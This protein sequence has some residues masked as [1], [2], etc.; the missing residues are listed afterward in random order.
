[1]NNEDISQIDNTDKYSEYSEEINENSKDN[2]KVN[3]F[4]DNDSE[5]NS[6]EDNDDFDK[7]SSGSFSDDSRSDDSRSEDSRSEDS[8]S[9]DSRSDD[10]RSEDSRSEDSRSDDSRSDKDLENDK[11]N[12]NPPIDLSNIVDITEDLKDQYVDESDLLIYQNTNKLDITDITNNYDEMSV[13][14][15]KEKCKEKNLPVSGNKTKLIERLK[16]N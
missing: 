16:E 2:E 13:N 12:I 1:M 3:D 6:S 4:L 9:D 11:E 8:R 7:A 14:E 10:S 5:D 15:L